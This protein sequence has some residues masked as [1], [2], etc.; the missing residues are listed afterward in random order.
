MNRCWGPPGARAQAAQKTVARALGFFA[1][2]SITTTTT[3][4]PHLAS[5][6]LV[7][8]FQTV[9]TKSF[10]TMSAPRLASSQTIVDERGW[11]FQ[12]PAL[13]IPDPAGEW[14]PIRAAIGKREACNSLL[15]DRGT[16]APLR[17]LK[18][19]YTVKEIEYEDAVWILPLLPSEGL[20]Q[21][22]YIFTVNVHRV[23]VSAA[24]ETPRLKISIPVRIVF[25]NP[26]AQRLECNPDFLGLG[27]PAALAESELLRICIDPSPS[28]CN[29]ATFATTLYG[30]MS[31][32]TAAERKK[33]ISEE[34]DRAHEALSAM[35]N[36][37][38]SEGWLREIYQDAVAAGLRRSPVFNEDRPIF[39]VRV[40]H[41]PDRDV[42]GLDYALV[43]DDEDFTAPKGG[44]WLPVPPHAFTPEY[45]RAVVNLFRSGVG[46]RLFSKAEWPPPPTTLMRVKGVQG[47]RSRT[48][49]VDAYALE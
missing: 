10:T 36:D 17:H 35:S 32:L 43:A 37:A 3:R 42:R 21:E 5:D 31:N 38:V 15:L 40:S 1:S 13:G 29:P 19:E 45:V 27:D 26:V 2:L 11:S 24:P 30:N 8:L 49:S 20:D 25:Y 7:A 39:K 47:G 18:G 14:T 12:L 41:E 6:F 9:A 23:R 34:R 22:P 33:R 48:D 4:Q 28:Q 46:K 16:R 44:N